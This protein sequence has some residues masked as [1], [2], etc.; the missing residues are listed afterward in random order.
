MASMQARM[1]SATRAISTLLLISF[2]SVIAFPAAV[3][4]QKEDEL[5]T[6]RFDV[7]ISLRSQGQYDEAIKMLQG[8]ID[9]Y[10]KSDK[11]LRRAYSELVFTIWKKGDVAGATESARN[12]LS[13]FPDLTPDPMYSSERVN[14]LYDNLRKQMFGSL[15][16]IA[17]PDS[18]RVFLGDDF[19]GFT[20]LDMRYVPVGEYVLNLSKAGYKEESYPVRIGPGSPTN[21]Q[22]ALQ[23]ERT[24]GWWLGRVVA[25]ASVVASF[26][27]IVFLGRDT[28]S[29]EPSPLPGPPAPPTR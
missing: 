25:P 27:A 17:R 15:S 1:S 21:M 7:V 14:E 16:V 11:I 2:L 8:I 10:A 23:K 19:A 28:G 18:C 13:H 20:S 4:A 26:V 6:E 22:L 12:A 9:E 29:S 5:I 24:K 3:L